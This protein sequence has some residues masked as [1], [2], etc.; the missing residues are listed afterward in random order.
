M[1][2]ENRWL[3]PEGID[4]ALPEQAQALE[5]LRR[6][7]VDLYNSWGYELVMPPFIEYLDSLL[8]GTGHDLELQTFTVTDQLSGRLLGV[9]ADMTPQ[10][11]R[12]DAHRLRSDL[13]TRLCY[14][15]TVLNTR[16]EGFSGTRSPLQ[17]G[18]ELYGHS[19]IES[20]VEI[21]SLM[22]ETMRLTGVQNV[23]VDLGHVGI[24]RGLA[25]QAGLNGAQEAALFEALQRKA[26]PE[27][28]AF[29]DK[30]S[31]DDYVEEMLRALS[32]L[33]GDATVLKEAGEV[34][35]HA[36]AD[37]RGALDELTAIARMMEA[38]LPN[39]PLYF[40]LAELRGY[41][42][43]TGI[44]FAAF[45]PGRGQAIAQGGRYDEIGKVF[46]RARPATG[47]SADLKTLVALGEQ[48][49]TAECNAI[50]A[51]ADGDSDFHQKV[52]EL[53]AQRERVI[54]ELSG[55]QGDAKAMGCSR[56]LVEQGGDWVVEPLD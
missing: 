35:E 23:H 32:D 26:K 47:F 56:V 45:V 44:V 53:R 22:L 31:I 1:S 37:V 2:E 10:V 8:T 21:L 50:F 20:D 40:D 55:Q 34:L 18:A 17:V 25:R 27:I 3:L 9:R 43:H 48:A 12:I 46:G 7:V 4:E 33:N 38:R 15:G 41:R 28:D 54:H 19:G 24:F 51:P 6:Q 42:Y 39:T 13:P 16:P 30:L 49:A 5:A 29:F 11:A 52:F 36:G 14:L